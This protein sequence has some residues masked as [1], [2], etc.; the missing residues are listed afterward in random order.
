MK[1]NHTFVAKRC[2]AGR[3]ATDGYAA[4]LHGDE[5]GRSDNDGARRV[6]AFYAAFETEPRHHRDAQSAGHRDR[7]GRRGERSALTQIADI[8]VWPDLK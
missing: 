7:T 1:L 8:L 2:G 4:G 3:Q 6:R 5:S